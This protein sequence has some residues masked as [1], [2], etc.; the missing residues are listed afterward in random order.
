MNLFEQ[1]I[2]KL[3]N[4]IAELYGSVG[5]VGAYTPLATAIEMACSNLHKAVDEYEQQLQN[6]NLI[7]KKQEQ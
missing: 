5:D 2:A 3:R 4:I 6:D 1:N 7:S